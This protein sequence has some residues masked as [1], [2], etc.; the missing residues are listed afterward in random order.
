MEE[1]VV[2]IT[3]ASSGIGAAI[4]EHF[5]EIGYRRISIVARR[6]E[7]LREVAERCKAKGAEDVLVLP[8]DL[9]D[10]E[11]ARSAVVKTVEHF[12]SKYSTSFFPVH[13]QGKASGLA[14]TMVVGLGGCI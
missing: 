10:M 8:L 12:E 1:K 5:S 4:A 9:S 6:E 7:K 3:G 14:T 2:L 11:S 13:L